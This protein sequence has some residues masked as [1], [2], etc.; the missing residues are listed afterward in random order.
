MEG[1]STRN[2]LFAL[3]ALWWL[4]PACQSFGGE[5]YDPCLSGIM[6]GDRWCEGNVEKECYDNNA[7]GHLEVHTQRDC[8]EYEGSICREGW[9][10][11]DVECEPGD[12]FCRGEQILH[13]ESATWAAIVKDCEEQ[14]KHCSWTGDAGSFS[15]ED[16]CS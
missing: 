10:G 16:G 15:I 9:C 4:L 11:Y 6:D 5:D 1:K 12:Y 13:C 8:D 7:A 2:A 14:D 3:V